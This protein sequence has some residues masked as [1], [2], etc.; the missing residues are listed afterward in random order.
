MHDGKRHTW[1]EKVRSEMVMPIPLPYEPTL[2]LL[3]FSFPSARHGGPSAVCDL[4]RTQ[5]RPPPVCTA[6]CD[7]RA[8]VFPSQLCSQEKGM[9]IHA[10]EERRGEERGDGE[11]AREEDKRDASQTPAAHPPPV[12]R[13]YPLSC[14]L[15]R[16]YFAQQTLRYVH[17]SYSHTHS[18][19]IHTCVC[20]F[21]QCGC[22]QRR[23]QQLKPT[24]HSHSRERSKFNQTPRDRLA[25]LWSNQQSPEACH[26]VPEKTH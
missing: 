16:L 13:P 25:P 2:M 21:F 18:I 4:R 24:R 9:N 5:G 22:S 12:P 8:S 19:R 14:A 11:A 17:K 20:V 3:Q 23:Q 15:L 6:S 1:L 10:G 7:T 26:Y